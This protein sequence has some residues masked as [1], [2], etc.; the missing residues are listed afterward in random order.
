MKSYIC[1]EK[2]V[3]MNIKAPA[4]LAVQD[5]VQVQMYDIY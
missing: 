4:L 5:G 1:L 2:M 3:R